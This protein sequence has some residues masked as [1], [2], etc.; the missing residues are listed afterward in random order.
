MKRIPVWLLG[1]L[2]ALSMTLWLTACGTVLPTETPEETAAETTDD[3]G[4]DT[5]DGE[6]TT[7]DTGDGTADG[8]QTTDDAGDDTAD[9]EQTT[10]DHNNDSSETEPAHI[11]YYDESGTCPTCSA[12]ITFTEGMEYALNDDGL[13]YTLI[14]I[15]IATDSAL[16]IPYTHEGKPVT[17]IGWT[18]FRNITSITSVFIPGSVE[19]IDYGAF[20]G[21]TSLVHVT[22]SEGILDIGQNAFRSCNIQTVA[23]PDSLIRMY[24]T[25]FSG[26]LNLMVDEENGVEYLDGWAIDYRGT[27]NQLILKEGTRGIAAGVFIGNT[28]LRVVE[29]PDTLISIDANA[30]KDCTELRSARLPAGLQYLGDYA[31]ANCPKLSGDLIIPDT[32][33]SVGAHA[34][35]SCSEL[36]SVKLGARTTIIEAFAFYGCRNVTEIH[37]NDIL[38]TIGANAF[39]N[40]GVTSVVLPATLQTLDTGA[41]SGCFSLSEL[42]LNQGL[43]AIGNNA[44]EGSSLTSLELPTTLESIGEGAFA[45]CEELTA[46]TF[47]AGL[48]FV[49]DSAFN[50]CTKLETVTFMSHT[51]SLGGNVFADCT[52][53]VSITIDDNA[54]IPTAP[55]TSVTMGYGVFKGCN[56]L[57]TVELSALLTE[58]GEDAFWNCTLLE[59]LFIPDGIAYFSMET[60][61]DC[62]NLRY[63]GHEG[64]FYLGN[65]ENPYLIL[66]FVDEYAETLVVHGNTRLILEEAFGRGQYL[67]DIT[68]SDNVIRIG[69]FAFMGCDNLRTIHLGKSVMDFIPENFEYLNNLVAFTVDEQNNY[70]SSQNG[71]LYNKDM[72]EVICVPNQVTGDIVLP[73][74]L[75]VIP[76]DM[77]AFRPLIETLTIP[78][79]VTEIQGNAFRNC[80]NLKTVYL[81]T[82]TA[83]IDS[84]AFWDLY[85]LENIIVNNDD[86]ETYYSQDGVLYTKDTTAILFVPMS[87]TGEISIPEGITTLY[88]DQFYHCPITSVYLPSTL[89]VMEDSTFNW[90]DQLTEF[91]YNGTKAEFMQINIGEYACDWGQITAVHCTDGS[92][93]NNESFL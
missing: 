33:V 81:F 93:T 27:A 90:C 88:A 84:S 63:N 22:L 57:Q 55:T 67:T 80:E 9:G 34:F 40:S 62:D 19:K 92:I 8:E 87:L 47:P 73:D 21:C 5:A 64:G 79:T 85:A 49:G 35:D 30:F 6:Q 14:D 32:L 31:F 15:G 66:C 20:E 77:L 45:G 3:A 72:S 37:F 1:T 70:F 60:I 38:E 16:Y 83:N 69:A 25:A 82:S 48:T 65:E 58:I 51:T 61:R 75:T 89:R 74:N 71:I 52:E 10:D 68:I 50:C 13:S 76:E 4:D 29:L 46:L 54:S 43:T 59:N 56:K 28:N 26:C 86:N 78:Y 18:A 41:F 44:F 7:D 17:C 2:V 39:K 24:R 11:C 36:T 91:H 12:V 42:T 53:L 23:L